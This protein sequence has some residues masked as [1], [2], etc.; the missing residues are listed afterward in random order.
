[1][2]EMI[3]DFYSKTMKLSEIKWYIKLKIRLKKFF[4]LKLTP[5]EGYVYNYMSEPLYAVL[6]GDDLLTEEQLMKNEQTA[7]TEKE[8]KEKLSRV[9]EELTDTL[10]REKV[11]LQGPL[12]TI[13][14]VGPWLLTYKYP[15]AAKF[16]KKE[17]LSEDGIIGPEKYKVIP[18]ALEALADYNNEFFQNNKEAYDLLCKDLEVLIRDH[19]CFDAYTIVG[20]IVSSYD[21][22]KDF[23]KWGA[24]HGVK[25]GMVSYGMCLYRDH[26]VEEGC[27]W[28]KQGASQGCGIGMAIMGVSY[29]F[30]TLTKIDYNKAAY[31]YK[32]F[33]NLE[34]S[35]DKGVEDCEWDVYVV[36]NL[37]SLFADAGYFHTARKYFLKAKE[38]AASCNGRIRFTGSLD[39]LQNV[40]S[41]GEILKFPFK[42]RRQHAVIQRQAPGFEAIFCES[43]KGEQVAPKPVFNVATDRIVLFS[44]SDDELEPEDLYEKYRLSSQQRQGENGV[45]FPYDS[46]F[47]PVHKVAIRNSAVRDYRKELIFLERN[48]HTELNGYIQSHFDDIKDLFRKNGYY[49][50]Y[51]PA[52]AVDNRDHIDIM[53][54]Y[55]EEKGVDGSFPEKSAWENRRSGNAYWNSFFAEEELPEDCAGFLQP[56]P[57]DDGPGGRAY[58][59]IVFPHRPG[60]DWGR[61][62]NT[63][64][65]FLTGKPTEDVSGKKL[66]DAATKIRIDKK[67]NVM[68]VDGSGNVVGEVKMPVLSK[69][70]YFVFLQH[71]EGIAIKE[72]TDYRT[73]LLDYYKQV[74]ARQINEKSIDDLVD[75]TKNSANEKI[76]RI[77]KAFEEALGHYDCDISSMVPTGRKGEKYVVKFNRDNVEWE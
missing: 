8:R 40:A 37:G 53:N 36:S 47:F 13:Y 59:Y 73:E 56:I 25:E 7:R 27:G 30:G 44:P 23:M 66:L 24:E 26:E 72:L 68:V 65:A 10:Q 74:S 29:Q 62:F 17:I 50:V 34:P 33:L 42:E 64:M 63:F 69:V 11:K 31:W 5:W 71:P 28:V 19:G 32:K 67:Y 51:L 77:R 57:E 39:L 48:V 70:L 58:R 46:F 54:S 38:L 35:D 9:P 20:S 22:H 55:L 6:F 16:L 1:M 76:S 14:T 21:E 75:P 49:F 52:H 61:A 60:T 12:F 18:G 2:I 41:C 43:P 45:R 4:C 15:V 3:H